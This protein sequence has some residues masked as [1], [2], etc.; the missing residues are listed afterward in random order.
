MISAIVTSTGG[1]SI[2]RRTNG[3]E[4]A[5]DQADRDPSDD[6]P[7]EPPGRLPD[8]ERSRD[9]RR[10]RDAVQDERRS[11]VHEA[12]AFDDGDGAPRH[13]QPAHD[14]GG[15]ERI[16]RR[17]HCAEDEGRAP[18][19]V[20]D[21]RVRDD[22]DRGHRRE[23][24][25][26]RERA[27]RTDVLPELPQ[28]REERG[29]IEERR[30]ERDQHE[31]RRQLER[32]HPRDEPER[33]AAEDEQDRVGNVQRRRRDEERRNGQQKAHQDQL[34]VD[35]EVHPASLFGARVATRRA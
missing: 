18:G 6:A 3:D 26:D 12:L 20:V 9:H 8:R 5:D 13:S 35:P 30:Q 25:P 33:Q 17:N 21:H 34:L 14:R 32:G 27:D 24:E 1:L 4:K 29:R 28:R 15:R 7:H 2:R 16:G 23:H 11:V 19:H 31:L 10:H 22:G